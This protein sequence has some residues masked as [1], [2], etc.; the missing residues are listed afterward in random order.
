MEEYSLRDIAYE[1]VGRGYADQWELLRDLFALLDYR[2]YLF[3]R[4]H[5][6][7]GP[8]NDLKNMLGLVVTRE[9]F[10]HNLEKSEQLGLWQRISED[11]RAQIEL[12]E[13]A[14]AE[15]LELTDK[16]FRLLELFER[17]A[18]NGFE[19]QCAVLAYA[20]E[21]D[22]KYERLFAY[23]Q[24]DITKKN[25]T[26]SL[27]VQLYLPPGSVVEEYIPAFSAPRPF[28]ALFDPEALLL[29]NLRLRSVVA[30]FLANGEIRTTC[31]KLFDGARDKPPGSIV[32][33]QTIA[34]ELDRALSSSSKEN[35][36]VLCGPPGSGRRFQLKHLMARQNKKCLFVDAKAAGVAGIAEAAL[37]VRLANAR[38]CF[39]NL[40]SRLEDG[41]TEN[42][43]ELLQAITDLEFDADIFLVCEKP[44]HFD[45]NRMT[46][47]LDFAPLEAS[48]RLELFAHFLGG[49]SLKED[50]SL[51]EV[52]S[53]FRFEPLQ[54]QKAC[55]QAASGGAAVDSAQ[56]HRCCYRQ[57]VHKLDKLAKRIQ[58]RFTWD[59]VVL[60][61]AQKKLMRQAT[62]HIRFAHTVY[63]EWGF[64][65]KL[66]YGKGLSILFAGAPGTGKTM[67]AQVIARQLNM[68]LYKIN[69]S[70]IVSKYIGETE[71]NLA[72]V[73]AEARKSNCI[74]FFDECDAIF[75]KRS[76]VKD[77]HDRNA[78]VEVAY[79]LQQI[80]EHDG[81]SILA[82]NLMQNIDAAFMRRITF[83]VHF[84][85]PDAQT[86]REIYLRTLP[87]RAPCEEDIDWDFLA[88]KFNLSGGH[89][90]NIVVCA[91][92]MAASE[93]APISMRHLLEAAVNELKKNEIVVV[94]EEL[95]E[96]A[97]LIFID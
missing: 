97:D 70:Q 40:E 73:F 47:A 33:R 61:G 12:G 20:A 87:K 23:L 69:I 5:Q 17:F 63:H 72:A 2:L 15:R 10:E 95:R 94:R 78:N 88:E 36:V 46:T 26:A 44:V 34:D 30:G 74:L 35:A 7:V 32:I 76:E 80:E 65:R 71:K 28:A 77:S 53:K 93:E 13:K 58:P 55:E 49:V 42:S 9:E 21:L 50:V 90:K 68:E 79:L 91:A 38:L 4:Y 11:E 1:Q 8:G 45:M 14:V 27:A 6:W 54:I 96:Y 60:P 82:T 25:P 43:P 24:D 48:E 3:Y 75:S 85:F 51:E 81:V 56:L 37:A 19:R 41:D 18:L 57:A 67:C 89:I 59:D 83:I 22:K 84:P 31:G 16:G 39:F 62:A 29:G 92:F 86:R 66:S 64:K 52:A